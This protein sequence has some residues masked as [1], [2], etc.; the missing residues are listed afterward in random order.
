M[1]TKLKLIR[2]SSKWRRRWM[3]LNSRSQKIRKNIK[4]LPKKMKFSLEKMINLQPNLNKFARTIYQ[5]KTTNLSFSSWKK[6]KWNYKI[7][8]KKTKKKLRITKSKTQEI[9][10]NKKILKK[11]TDNWLKNK[12]KWKTFI[13]TKFRSSITSFR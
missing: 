11:K 2:W 5:K 8:Q 13:K 3:N 4:R 7:F 12:R 1:N 9:I 10:K 6:K